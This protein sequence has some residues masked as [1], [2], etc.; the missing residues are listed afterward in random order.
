M[1]RV[2]ARAAVLLIV[3][4]ASCAP[5]LAADAHGAADR[6]DVRALDCVRGIRLVARQ[7]TTTEVLR[8][9]S[10]VEGFRLTMEE[11]IEQR[12]DLDAVQPTYD[13]L[14]RLLD[15]RS[16]VISQRADPRCPGRLRVSRIWVLKASSARAPIEVVAGAAPAARVDTRN[17][18][19]TPEAREQDEMYQRAHGMLPEK[20][21]PP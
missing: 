5:A 10:D 11:P 4:A 20:V 8:R 6:V 7:A 16:F 15:A 3:G 17:W 13:V 18:Q 9:L 14:V 1:R 12:L 19:V 2:R 21:S